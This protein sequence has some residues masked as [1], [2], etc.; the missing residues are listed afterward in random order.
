MI[1]RKNNTSV[2]G[3]LKDESFEDYFVR[4]NENKN[5]YGITSQDIA[6]LLNAQMGVNYNESTWRK[7]YANFNQG[8]IYERNKNNRR[9]QTRILSISDLHI[10]FELPVETFRKYSGLVDILVLN[11]DILDCQSISKFSKTYRVSLVEEMILARTYI[12]NLAELIAPKKII[13]TLGNHENRMLRYLSDN[14]NENILNIM[15]DSPMDLIIN[16]GFKNKDRRL[17]V[18]SYYAPLADELEIPISYT[19]DWYCRIGNVLFA[20]PLTYS[21]AIMKTADRAVSYFLRQ[22]DTRDINAIV[23]AHT[24]KV[25]Y[26][27]TGDIRLYEQGCCCNISQIDYANGKLM[28]PQQCGYIYCCLDNCGNVVDESTRLESI[29][30]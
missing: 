7:R 8:R 18:E 30:L 27:M 15:P 14:L 29:Q 25:G 16:D 5:I 10:P 21:S 3:V 13:I 1:E 2:F 9:V 11:G 17:R 19:G 23:L 20:H 12:I 28:Y 26:Y 22:N 6:D 4:L 24:H